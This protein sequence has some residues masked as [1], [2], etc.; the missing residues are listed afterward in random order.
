MSAIGFSPAKW[1]MMARRIHA[2]LAGSGAACAAGAST[3]RPYSKTVLMKFR[4][5]EGSSTWSAEQKPSS[6]DRV[7]N[8]LSPFCD[9]DVCV[10]K[11]LSISP[12]GWPLSRWSNSAVHGDDGFF[13]SIAKFLSS[14]CIVTM[15][16]CEGSI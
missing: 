5:L 4:R 12:I 16:R 14:A 6:V 9:F 8:L 10:M 2:K 7:L 15:A 3:A 13:S 1:A 11:R